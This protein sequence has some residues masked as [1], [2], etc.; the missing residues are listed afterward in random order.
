MTSKGEEV[1]YTKGERGKQK[2]E[3]SPIYKYFAETREEGA[4][5]P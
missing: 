4:L 2:I 1:L 5:E 3:R